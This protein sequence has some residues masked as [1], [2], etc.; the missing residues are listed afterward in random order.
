MSYYP[1]LDRHIKDKVKVILNLSNYGTKVPTKKEL[2]HATGVDTCDL[3]A[4]KDFIAIKNEVD[5]LNIIKLVNV[6]TC[7]N[8][9]K[10]KVDD[11][12][13]GELKTVP[14]D[15]KKLSGKKVAKI[16]K[17]STLERKVNKLDKKFLMQLLKFILLNTT[18]R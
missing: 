2:E 18:Q 9:L 15:F 3:A 1:E 4:T 8:N 7:V 13:V 14:I 16:T 12:D 6:P 17:F 10:T 5:K 11:L